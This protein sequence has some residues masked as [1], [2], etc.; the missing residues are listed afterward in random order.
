LKPLISAIASG[1]CALI[2]PSELSPA[3]AACM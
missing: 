3:T 2:K 1:N